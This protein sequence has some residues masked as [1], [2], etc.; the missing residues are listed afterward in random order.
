MQG[1]WQASIVND[2]AAPA[3][4]PLVMR[5]ITSGA[6]VW[7]GWGVSQA[8]GIGAAQLPSNGR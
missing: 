7:V 1:L 5:A 8:V 6:T 3:A 4:D 2:F